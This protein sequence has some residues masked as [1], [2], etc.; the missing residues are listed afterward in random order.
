MIKLK[1]LAAAA[2]AALS[3]APASAQT[4][5]VN[6]ASTIA[7]PGNNDFGAQLAALGL[8]RYASLGSSILL[9]RASTVSFAF[10]GSESG[11][12]D[13][14]TAGSATFTQDP[15]AN[16]FATPVVFGSD[17]FNAGAFLARYTSDRGLMASIGDE[18]FGIFLPE[19]VGATYTASV[20]YFGYDNQINNAD[21]NHDDLIIR[22]TAVPEPSTWFM[23]IAGF[24]LIGMAR[25]SRGPV[26]AD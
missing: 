20:L 16:A 10:L 2:A 19:N 9:D 26:V 17:T 12:I 24:G 13:T 15:D 22:A 18:G 4:F 1:F 25:R 21:D 5:T 3:V 6:V 23:M 7:V 14:F 11:F 8:T